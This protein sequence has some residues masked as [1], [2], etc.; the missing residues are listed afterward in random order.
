MTDI[1]RPDVVEAVREAFMGYER[2]LVTNDVQAL[3]SYFWRSDHTIR[4]GMGENLYG[5][6]QIA[7]FRAAR[8]ASGLDRT[9]SNTTIT[10]FG[11]DTAVANTE[12]HRP[13]TD[14]IG[15]QS[16]TW[17]RFPDGWKVVSAHVSL[18]G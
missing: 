13:S 16:Q 5:Y 10:T 7:A 6:D 4:Y 14:R 3:D 18:M 2:A 17:R 12:F 1:N 15:R 11:D 9:L 8:P